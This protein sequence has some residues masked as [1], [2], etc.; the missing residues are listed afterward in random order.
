MLSFGSLQN[1]RAAVPE[2]TFPMPFDDG[3]ALPAPDQADQAEQAERAELAA[4]LGASAAGDARA[5]E[6][7]YHRTV[8]HASAVV[9]RIVGDNHLEDVLS[10]AYFQAWREAARFNAQRGS[11]RGWLLA[12]ARSRA[13]DRLRQECVRHGGLRGAPDPGEREDEDQRQ[14]GPDDLL[15]STEACS[16]LHAAVARLSVNERWVLGLA[17]FRDLN[18]TEIAA[19]TELPLGTVKSLISRS[20]HKLRDALCAHAPMNRAAL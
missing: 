14:P 7:F 13:L 15:A 16:Q 3:A 18:H 17:Y 19:L 6:N 8:R 11:A 5:F 4:L 10:D 1:L 20:Q 2:P 9:R 12:I